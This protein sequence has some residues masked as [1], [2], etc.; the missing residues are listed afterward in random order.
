MTISLPNQNSVS[1]VKDPAPS[2]SAIFF[3]F[4]FVCVPSFLRA[5]IIAV[6]LKNNPIHQKAKKKNKQPKR[7]QFRFLSSSPRGTQLGLALPSCCLLVSL[8][9]NR[10]LFFYGN[11]VWSTSGFID[12]RPKKVDSLP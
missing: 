9:G 2:T 4:F 8:G 6:Y 1:L 5:C 3:S 12:C 7:T 11:G 10:F